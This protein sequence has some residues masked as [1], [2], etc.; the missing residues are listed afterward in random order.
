MYLKYKHIFAYFQQKIIFVE[1]AFMQTIIR[2]WNL[3]IVTVHWE[4]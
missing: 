3:E 2:L 1:A 4:W